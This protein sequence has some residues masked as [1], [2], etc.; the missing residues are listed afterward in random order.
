MP[1]PE[2]S[3]LARARLRAVEAA[4]L[5]GAALLALQAE[6][7]AQASGEDR[8]AASQD[9]F[10]EALAATASEADAGLWLSQFLPALR[11]HIIE[12]FFTSSRTFGGALMRTL[13]YQKLLHETLS[14]RLVMAAHECYLVDETSQPHSRH[15]AECFMGGVIR[16]LDDVS[17]GAFVPLEIHFRHE[18]GAGPER[19][20]GIY[21]CP[22][23]LGQ[24]E[25][26]L[27]FNPA[28]LGHETW[29]ADLSLQRLH[30]QIAEDK[31]EEVS[32]LE[33]V[34][35]VRRAISQ[36]L[37]GG[38]FGIDAIAARLGMTRRRLQVELASVETSYNSILNDYRLGLAEQLL[39]STQS[40]ENIVYLT[41]FSDPSAFY[42]AF[43]RWTGMTPTEF[44]ERHQ[45]GRNVAI[46]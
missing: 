42:R 45:A 41:G 4:G 10:W 39:C 30:E 26:R 2:N 40:I 32:R 25:T 35:R 1:R 8:M 28:S 15:L 43:R 17:E 19:Y 9:A 5:D 31:L 22:V 11:G 33:L 3:I 23:R 36:S 6:L 7:L 20:A 37:E 18:Q 24:A 29:H 14:L 12:Y 13:A 44:R 34:D 27:Y 46:P 38:D 21:G 16:F